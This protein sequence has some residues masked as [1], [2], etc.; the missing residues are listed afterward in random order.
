MFK[1]MDLVQIYRELGCSNRVYEYNDCFQAIDD[2]TI[3]RSERELSALETE[4]PKA[5]E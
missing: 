5:K 4:Y 3:Q 2:K 1:G